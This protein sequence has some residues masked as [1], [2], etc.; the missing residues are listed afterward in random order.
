M[1]YFNNVPF[2]RFWVEVWITDDPKSVRVFTV[3][4]L[5]DGNPFTDVP[6]IQVP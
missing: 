4:V 2:G 3:D 5:R 6:P 1:Y